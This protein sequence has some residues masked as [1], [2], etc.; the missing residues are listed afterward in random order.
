VA[1]ATTAVAAAQEAAAA[2]REV[3][4]AAKDARAANLDFYVAA[5]TV[6]PVLMIAVSLQARIG[7]VIAPAKRW[8]DEMR[9]SL[10][11]TRGRIEERRAEVESIDADLR[12]YRS[13]AWRSGSPEIAQWRDLMRRVEAQRTRAATEAA[14]VAELR[15]PPY[16][17]S[18][19]FLR[20]WM[21]FYLAVGFVAGLV[22]MFGAT[23]G[24]SVGE[25]YG[26]VDFCVTTGVWSLA[27][28][29][30]FGVS[31]QLVEHLTTPPW[32]RQARQ[33]ES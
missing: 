5:V 28:F 33:P 4:R 30:A 12:R 13:Q 9:E 11:A 15:V 23:I 25:R 14:E 18:Y 7:S 22:G 10:D 32:K 29:L 6:I 17:R 26:W 8:F 19:R 2:A 16:P 24:L 21:L 27:A 1:T 20:P 3:A 31:Y